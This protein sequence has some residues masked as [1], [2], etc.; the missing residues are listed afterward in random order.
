MK[1]AFIIFFLIILYAVLSDNM[2]G[3]REAASNYN[4]L[5]QNAPTSQTIKK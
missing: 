2:G 5:L 1:Y 4:K 3:A